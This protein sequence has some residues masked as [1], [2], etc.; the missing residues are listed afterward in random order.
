ME[1]S[2]DTA[3]SA[4]LN[5]ITAE[6]NTYKRI[7]GEAIF[8]IGRRLK[9]VRY[10]PAAYNLPSGTDKDGRTIVARG[11]WGSWLETVGM[12]DSQ[13]RRYIT[14]VERLGKRET[15]HDKGL[16]ALYLIATLPPD[17]RERPQTIPSTGE[18]KRPDEMTV[19]ELRRVNRS[20]HGH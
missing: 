17:E 20:G 6:I 4:D 5:V 12:D 15:S 14:V 9:H 7:A 11:A 10:N 18:M 13:S 2:I 3:L 19:R 8:E 16:D 1:T